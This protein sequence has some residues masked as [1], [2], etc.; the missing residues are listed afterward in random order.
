MSGGGAV[1]LVEVRGL[2]PAIAAADVMAK[3]APVTIGPS[4]S[5]GDGLVTV[6]CRGQVSAVLEAVE[7]GSDIAIRLGQLVASRTFGRLFDEVGV[8]FGFEGREP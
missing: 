7:A 6:V 3:A 8:V 5:I 1:G 2:T 4:L